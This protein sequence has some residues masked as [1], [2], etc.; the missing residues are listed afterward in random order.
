MNE[1]IFNVKTKLLKKSKIYE[2]INIKEINIKNDPTNNLFRERKKTNEKFLKKVKKDDISNQISSLSYLLSEYTKTSKKN[3]K[4]INE[5]KTENDFLLSGLN[6][7]LQKS[8]LFNKKTDEVF[9]DLIVQ[10]SNKGYKIPNLDRSHNLFK[11]S[12]LLIENKDDVDVFYQ[13]DPSTKGNFITDISDFKEKNWLFLNKLNK[14]CHKAKTFFSA[15]HLNIDSNRINS[16]DLDNPFG[17]KKINK[18]N[19]SINNLLEEINNLKNAIK[20][21]EEK[22]IIFSYTSKYRNNYIRKH[23][24]SIKAFNIFNNS[25]QQ[26]F[27]KKLSLINNNPNKRKLSEFNL[28]TEVNKNKKKLINNSDKSIIYSEEKLNEYKRMKIPGS[29]KLKK[30]IKLYFSKNDKKKL[31]EKLKTSN[32]DVLEK[33]ED[34]K[35]TI[36]KKDI[37][38]I[39]KN[40]FNFSRAHNDKINLVRHLE[41]KLFN[42]DKMF[43]QQTIGK[44]FENA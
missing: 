2:Q 14:E 21:E 7:N 12:P 16:N 17:V 29:E 44:S 18:D 4:L 36:R 30:E 37:L 42:L 15:K 41:K 24:Q 39:H 3:L 34:I 23:S 26:I 1:R 6:N 8:A 19:N 35:R 11:R 40:Y 13:D 27:K 38:S 43:I 32:A 9:H 33:I 10:Y 28:I 31:F 25:N 5:L 22:N 20:K